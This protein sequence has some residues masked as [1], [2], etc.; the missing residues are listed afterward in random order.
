MANWIAPLGVQPTPLAA[1]TAL[2]PVWLEANGPATAADL[3][4]WAG[5]SQRDA[6][7][8]LKAI[9][10]RTLT[11]SGI[12]G[13]LHASE[14]T[15]A[16][17]ARPADE[18]DA[19]HLVPCWDSYVMAHRDRSRYLDDARRAFVLDAMGNSTSVILRAPHGRDTG[20]ARS[21]R[22]GANDQAATPARAARWDQDRPEVPMP[23]PLGRCR[24][25]FLA[26]L[27]PQAPR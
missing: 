23:P 17:L 25:T 16:S 12:A 13:E 8:A 14:A 22:R 2:A 9:S 21:G 7:A 15:L 11:V 4:W 27:R 26:P 18:E 3:A 19:I 24:R 6:K 5:T 10:S 1:L 20:I